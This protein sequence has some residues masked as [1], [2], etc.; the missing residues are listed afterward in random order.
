[1]PAVKSVQVKETSSSYEVK[2]GLETT[3]PSVLT[4][5]STIE[6]VTVSA[7]FVNM[8]IYEF[9]ILIDEKEGVSS[10]EDD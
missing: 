2:S 4:T 9:K 6:L 7:L 8:L 1:M 10:K 5:A 3:T